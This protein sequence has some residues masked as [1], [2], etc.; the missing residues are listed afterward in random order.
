V[1]IC[2]KLKNAKKFPQKKKI[3][4]GFGEFSTAPCGNFSPLFSMI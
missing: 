4:T 1:E 2:G 3:S